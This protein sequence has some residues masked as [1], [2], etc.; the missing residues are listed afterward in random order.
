MIDYN[1]AV[2]TWGG[3]RGGKTH[4][5]FLGDEPLPDHAVRERILVIRRHRRRAHPRGRHPVYLPRDEPVQRRGG[6]R[7]VLKACAPGKKQYPI[8]TPIEG[9][10]KGR[11]APTVVNTCPLPWN[12]SSGRIVRL[13]TACCTALPEYGFGRVTFG[14]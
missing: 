5:R 3:G 4:H 14:V 1:S 2:S 8:S 9:Q 6:V 13:L 7:P 10:K 11:D 12:I